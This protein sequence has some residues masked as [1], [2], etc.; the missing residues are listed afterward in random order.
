LYTGACECTI[1]LHDRST[2]KPGEKMGTKTGSKVVRSTNSNSRVIVR[3]DKNGNV[4]TETSRR[5]PGSLEL[6]ISTN[7]RMNSTRLF[8]DCE[9]REFGYPTLE[10]NG[11]EARTLFLALRKHF[12]AVGLSEPD[13][14]Y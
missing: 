13:L 6:A 1:S 5:D 12:D 3:S 8:I 14:R 4:R 9:G 10:F 7:P 11:R 2:I